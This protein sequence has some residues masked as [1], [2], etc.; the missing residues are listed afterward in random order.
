MFDLESEGCIAL[1]RQILSIL[2]IVGAELLVLVSPLR[3]KTVI[4]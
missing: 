3:R 2:S 1:A 4:P